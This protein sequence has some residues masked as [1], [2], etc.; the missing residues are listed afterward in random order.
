ML[1]I[2][3]LRGVY[4]KQSKHEQILAS[5]DDRF[6]DHEARLPDLHARLSAKTKALIFHR[7]PGFESQYRLFQKKHSR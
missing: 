3:V 5:L 6:A 7:G 4:A 2:Y 1:K